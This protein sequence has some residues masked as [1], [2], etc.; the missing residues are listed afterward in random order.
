MSTSQKSVLVSHIEN[1]LQSFAVGGG[2]GKALVKKLDKT[3]T[4]QELG[5]VYL[6]LIEDSSD[7]LVLDS[8]ETATLHKI[9]EDLLRS[10]TVKSQ[11]TG[12]TLVAAVKAENAGEEHPPATDAE[13]ALYLRLDAAMKREAKRAA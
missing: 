5:G 4:A 13:M 2:K 11:T 6:K 10:F 12:K 8:G 9:L 3:P 7:L 1:V